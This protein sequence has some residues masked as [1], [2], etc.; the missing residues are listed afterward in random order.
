MRVRSAVTASLARSALVLAIAL[1][2]GCASEAPPPAPEKPP[3][4]PTAIQALEPRDM[5]E[6]VTRRSAFRWKLPRKAAEPRLLS[7][8]LAQAGTAAAP[9]KD[10]ER[11]TRVAFASGLQTAGQGGIDPWQPPEG[12][13][14]TG[15]LTSMEQLD[16]GTWY[17]WSVR[18]LGEQ[19]ATHATFY[20]R[21]RA[22]DAVPPAPDAAAPAN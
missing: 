1:A 7:F 6:Q 9:E 17:R 21:T 15:V 13:V 5:A 19:Q 20:F 18:A 2:A 3:A 11:Q 12:C 10:E 8:T 14:L 22:D 16:A 4:E